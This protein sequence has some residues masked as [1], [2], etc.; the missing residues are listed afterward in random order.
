LREYKSILVTQ[1]GGWIGD[2]V[3]LTP[4]L[5]AL[6]KRHPSAHIAMLVRPIV[7]ELMSKHP[8]IDELIVYDKRCE[9]KGFR[10]IWR[11]ARRLQESKFNLAVVL[12]PN[13]VRSALI[14]H[15]ARIP[16]RIGTRI[17]G[18]GIFLTKTV[19]D[20]TDIHELERYLRVLKLIGIDK[21]DKELEFWHTPK[22][23]RIAYQLLEDCASPH[24]LRSTLSAPR[25]SLCVLRSTLLVGINPGTTWPSKRWK[26][27]RFANLITMLVEKFKARIVLT[28]APSEEG[29]GDELRRLTSSDFINLIGKTSLLQ[30]GALIERLNLYITCDSGP[31]HIAAA[32]GTPTIALFGPTNPVRH[33]PY[34]DTHI[35]IQKDVGCNPCYDRICNRHH[36]C[37]RAIEVDEVIAVLSLVCGN[38]NECIF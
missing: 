11:M 26:L 18:R 38:Q 25:S 23:G 10:G 37:M 7:E 24:A 30:L 3:L 27:E 17:S 1:T 9:N 21:T 31:M 28:G 2:M 34:G 33:R 6:R 36:E 29:L 16:E 22:D 20:R 8:Y 14:P 35:V 32:V 15:L 12:H 4:T 5:R 13:S 19:E